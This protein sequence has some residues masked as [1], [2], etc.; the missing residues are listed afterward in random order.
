MFEN[1]LFLINL[2]KGEKSDKS[3]QKKAQKNNL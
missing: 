1:S 3:V 2:T